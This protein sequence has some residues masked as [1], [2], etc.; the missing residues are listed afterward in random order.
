MQ[1]FRNA[2]DGA[3]GRD[4]AGDLDEQVSYMM[5][6]LEEIQDT[7]SRLTAL[8]PDSLYYGG[9]DGAE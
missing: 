8:Y 1:D 5:T 2:G 9:L 3:G 4:A 6:K 7:L